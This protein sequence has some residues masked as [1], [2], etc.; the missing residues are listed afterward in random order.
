MPLPD[1]TPVTAPW[2]DYL[3]SLAP[4]QRALAER[5]VPLCLEMGRL[6]IRNRHSALSAPII[7][8][9]EHSLNTSGRKEENRGDEAAV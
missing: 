5:F 7:A 2:R 9:P 1:S 4:D 3:A 6:L 8:E